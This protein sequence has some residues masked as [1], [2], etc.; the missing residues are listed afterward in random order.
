MVDS[1]LCP[2]INTNVSEIC[3]KTD[4]QVKESNK[5]KLGSFPKLVVNSWGLSFLQYTG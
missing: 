5:Q 3:C 2:Y 1:K 4:K